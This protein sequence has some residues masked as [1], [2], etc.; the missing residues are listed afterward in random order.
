MLEAGWGAQASARRTHMLS[1][2]EA[3]QDDTRHG[4]VFP[5]ISRST[6]RRAPVYFCVFTCPSAPRILHTAATNYFQKHFVQNP[7]GAVCSVCDRL[8]FAKDLS[9]APQ[10]SHGILPEHFPNRDIS[11]FRVCRTCR[12][13]LNE[14]KI[15]NY[16]TSNGYVYP[17][18]PSYLPRLNAVSERLIA[19]RIPF[20]QIRRLVYH[21][22][23]Q[24]SITG[25][26]VNVPISVPKTIAILPNKH[27]NDVALHVNIKRPFLAVAN[28]KL[29]EI[30]NAWFTQLSNSVINLS[31]TPPVRPVGEEEEMER[32]GEAE[33]RLENLLDDSGVTQYE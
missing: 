24:L 14:V 28:Q 8:W 17:P 1:R 13:S 10:H 20:M 27:V 7:F 6:S 9:K 5:R 31:P 22:S 23:G 18:K 30:A 2:P 26:I 11:A 4:M 15:P 25:P 29:H 12:T 21:T 19:P 32:G 33:T 3:V 16:S